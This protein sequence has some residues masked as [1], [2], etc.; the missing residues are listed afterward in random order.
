MDGK[1]DMEEVKAWVIPEDYDHS[2]A[3]ATHLVAA[4]DVDK[5]GNHFI[6]PH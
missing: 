1:L 6:F 4:S 2:S 3:E 5:V